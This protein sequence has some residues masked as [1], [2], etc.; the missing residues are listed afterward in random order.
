MKKMRTYIC[1]L[2]RAF[3]TPVI[4]SQPSVDAVPSVRRLGEVECEGGE[5]KVEEER[6]GRWS[7]PRL[8]TA[9]ALTRL[10]HLDSNGLWV[11]PLV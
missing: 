7:S 8:L 10:S 3:V 6:D 11:I 2:C 5:K 9:A 4:V 1:R